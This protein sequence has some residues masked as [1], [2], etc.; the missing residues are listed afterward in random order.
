M[1]ERI[2]SQLSKFALFSVNELRPVALPAAHEI[3]IAELLGI[4]RNNS[5]D[6]SVCCQILRDRVVQARPK[7]SHRYYRPFSAAQLNEIY[8]QLVG[9]I[10]KVMQS[11]TLKKSLLQ[12]ETA[13]TKLARIAHALAEN[14]ESHGSTDRNLATRQQALRL[15][16]LP[17]T[18]SVLAESYLD[19]AEAWEAMVDANARHH[20]VLS[21]IEAHAL[22]RWHDNHLLSRA[23]HFAPRVVEHFLCHRD[24]N[25]A[26]EWWLRALHMTRLLRVQ[27]A[28]LP[29][30]RLDTALC[31]LQLCAFREHNSMPHL[32]NDFCNVAALYLELADQWRDLERGAEYL[33]RCAALSLGLRRSSRVFGRRAAEKVIAFFDTTNSP[34]HNLSARQIGQ[35]CRAYDLLIESWTQCGNAEKQRTLLSNKVAFEARYSRFLGTR[36]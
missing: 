12:G 24:H 36:D 33:L 29:I 34:P 1:F 23:V 14:F 13:P 8:S 25:E 20:A 30:H 6:A 7:L 11:P 31:E 15:S 26:N 9:C 3:V 22:L 10:D 18:R 19:F 21:Y 5:G 35:V 4:A 28:L 27:G 2:A 17:V 32:F 16:Q